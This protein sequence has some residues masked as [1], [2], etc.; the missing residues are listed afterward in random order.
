MMQRF[1]AWL[2]GAEHRKNPP[3]PL[4]QPASVRQEAD[5]FDTY[6]RGIQGPQAAVDIFRGIWSS[7]LPAHLGLTAGEAPLFDD[8]RL[9]WLF[10]RLGGI[11]GW[12]VLELGPL[13][14]GH[15][16]M[17]QQAGAEHILAIDACAMSYLKCLLVKDL[18]G[19]DRVEFRYGDF[20]ALME[21]DAVK[22][23]LIVASGVLYHQ[24]DPLACLARMA[25]RSDTL[26]LWTHYYAEDWRSERVRREMF[27]RV[28]AATCEGFTC[29]LFR[30]EYDTYLPGVKYRGGVDNHV[31]W[32]RREDILACLRHH[33]FSDIEIAFEQEAHPYGPSFALLARRPASSARNKP[34][35]FCAIMRALSGPEPWCVDAMR[36]EGDHLSVSGWAIPP[37]GA[38]ARMGFLVNGQ[39]VARLESGIPREDVGVFYWYYPG[40]NHSGF[41]WRHPVDTAADA[42]L[43]LQYID[44]SSNTVIALQHDFYILPKDLRG[45][46]PAPPLKLI[47]R[48]HTGNAIDQYFIEGYTAYRIIGQQI[49]EI[50]GRPLA[51]VGRL[52]DFGCGPGRLARYLLEE[53]GLELV[54]LDADPECVTWCQKHLADAHFGH[55]PLRPPLAMADESVGGVWAI[56]VLLHLGEQDGR[57]WLREWRR[58][59]QPRGI[60][61]LTIASDLAMT[62]TG[63][64]AEHYE[65]VKGYGF[66]ELSRNPDLDDVIEDRDYYKNVFYSHD[67]LHRNW[68]AQGWEI[69]SIVPGCIG[70]HH[71]LVLLR[72]L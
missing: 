55:S 43:H 56:N 20:M 26:F 5:R 24:R 11:Q 42:P 3:E 48:T 68:P 61:A 71:D 22:Y 1:R 59:C 2:A 27:T 14:G 15:S 66:L 32:M 63:I 13:E 60:L 40:A 30:L 46:T 19:L 62:R 6:A 65:R 16:Y 50:T 12:N 8:A 52:L 69:L 45:E 31:H 72:R 7:A 28:P 4:S 53:P 29:E 21:T 17:L 34:A 54:G 38:L 35:D 44:T 51:T 39:P 67:Y 33:G 36:L 49:R 64:S 37:S 70:N 18:C 9:H 10:D 58:V 23:D 47:L 25:H 41:S 57:N